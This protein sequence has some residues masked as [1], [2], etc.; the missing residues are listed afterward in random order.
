[1]PP[2]LLDV[3]VVAALVALLAV[4]FRHPP[5][6]VE[7]LAGLAAAGAVLSLVRLGGGARR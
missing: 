6:R 2:A 3:V 5:A 4:A 7:V 1:M